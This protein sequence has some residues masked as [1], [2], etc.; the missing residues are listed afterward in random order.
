YRGTGRV[1]TA[2]GKRKELNLIRRAF[3]ERWAIPPKVREELVKRLREVIDNET[4]SR[5]VVAAAKAILEADRLNM[6]QEKRDG[7]IP[8]RVDVTSGG[9]PLDRDSLTADDL[10]AAMRLVGV[11]RGRVQADG[12]QE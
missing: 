9:K 10:A 5:A 3:K 4:D 8:D 11:A 7:D 6:E 1:H 2:M 12:G